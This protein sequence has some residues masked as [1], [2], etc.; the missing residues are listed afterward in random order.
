MA[1]REWLVAY[2]Q[3][4][5]N[6][7]L[8]QAQIVKCRE[9]MRSLGEMQ[10][11]IQTAVVD[12]D[13]QVTLTG[14]ASKLANDTK[15]VSDSF[16]KNG[17]PEI[18]IDTD[19]AKGFSTIVV[20]AR[21]TSGQTVDNT[22][23]K[24][25]YVPAATNPTTNIATNMSSVESATKAPSA[26]NTKSTAAS[27]V[28]LATQPSANAMSKVKQDEPNTSEFFIDV[29]VYLEGVQIPH[30]SATVSYGLG[31][32][33][34]CTIIL[35]ATSLIRDLPETTKVHIFF[36]DLLPDESG[37]YQWRLLFDGEMSGF[38]YNIDPNGATMSISALHSSAYISLMQLMSLDAAEYIFDS[39]PRLI[40][41]ATMT[42]VFGQNKVSTKL[43]DSIMR[44][45]G[46]KSMADIV[47][48]LMRAV[49]DGTQDSAVGKYYHDKLSNDKDAWKLLKRI[50]GVSKAV[51]ESPVPTY[52]KQYNNGT[53]SSGAGKDGG[54]MPSNGS[55]KIAD[56]ALYYV[57]IT[58]RDGTVD[59]ISNFQCDGLVTA[60]LRRAGVEPTG[61]PEH[62]VPDQQQYFINRGWYSTNPSDV[63]PGD[64]IIMNCSEEADHTGIFMRDANGVGYLVHNSASNRQTTQTKWEPPGWDRFAYAGHGRIPAVSNNVG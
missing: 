29:E 28:E 62:W 38:Q 55:S 24:D 42:T 31:S 18:T 23:P 50:Y 19:K 46:Y 63:Q 15:W 13:F 21:D 27:E 5:N 9:T 49:L 48:Q 34:S 47:Y 2:S 33:P 36:K 44:G 3:A 35:P 58:G 53:T 64:V 32:P 51:A 26:A 56:A 8:T 14:E 10:D 17:I 59:G 11:K 7:Q 54:I 1:T 60:S 52:D 16:V 12:G 30:S 4:L 6:S 37:T 20:R 39:N 41:D 61:W 40:G 45:K 57:G 22:V 25:T 43:I